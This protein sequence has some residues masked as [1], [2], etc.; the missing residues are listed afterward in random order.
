MRSARSPIVW[1]RYR[2][3]GGAGEPAGAVGT[4]AVVAGEL[5]D[6]SD[7]AAEAG[8]AEAIDGS[9]RIALESVTTFSLG[10]SPLLSRARS[11]AGFVASLRGLS[12]STVKPPVPD[13][14]DLSGSGS[15]LA[16]ARLMESVA[17][18]SALEESS[19]FVAL[20]GI[21]CSVCGVSGGADLP[22]LPCF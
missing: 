20:P 6:D 14:S 15:T 8:G 17:D 9:G 19:S 16:G 18:V 2:E 5:E 12:P 21:T 10:P 13:G 11:P 22:R 4:V 1:K 3:T 7:A